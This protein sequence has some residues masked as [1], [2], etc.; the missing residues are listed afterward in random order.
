MA[1]QRFVSIAVHFRRLLSIPVLIGALGGAGCASQE[2]MTAEALQC[3]TREVTIISSRFSRMGSE[4]AWC[5]T[6]R[7]KVYRCVTNA[8]RSRTECAP[9]REGDGCG[10]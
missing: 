4:T 7:G 8:Q 1:R 6:C 10:G 2:K 9:S 5:A 3:G